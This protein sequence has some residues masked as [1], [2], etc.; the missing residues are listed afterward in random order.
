MAFAKRIFLFLAIN[1]LVVIAISALLSL[2]NVRPYLTQV[3][4]DYQ[5]LMIFCL[6][7]GMGGALISLSLSRVMAK[8]LM[9]VKLIDPDTKDPAQRHL[10][11]TVYALSRKAHLPEMPQVGL[12]ESPEV[13]AFATGPTQRRSLVAISRGLLNKM[14]QGEIEGILGHEITH[15]ANGDMVTMTLVQGVVN[16]FVMFLARV[17]A[18]IFAGLGK[19]RRSGSGSSYAT[20]TIMVF[21][22]EIAFMLLG[23]LLI[24]WYS[25]FR[26]F[27][28][29]RGG[30]EL[31][32]KDKMISALKSLQQTMNQRDQKVEQPAFQAFKIST[33]R[34]QGL[35]WLF[36][37]HPPLEVRI[38][39]LEE[40]R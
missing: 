7:W 28:A 40:M 2:F 3:G 24:A 27:R 14:N 29:D 11:N 21:V 5:S 20:Y 4:L 32:G 13:N 23:S 22:F 9:G 38:E 34:K 1:F 18:Y 35:V 17:L 16:A 30:A 37:S 36:A 33:P 25:R 8:A 26:E 15:V 19:D 31:A 6:I 12:Y 39:R 10:L